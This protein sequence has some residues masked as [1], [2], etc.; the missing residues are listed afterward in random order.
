MSPLFAQKIEMKFGSVKEKVSEVL[1]RDSKDSIIGRLDIAKN[2]PFNQLP[3][4]SY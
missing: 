2:N 4:M 3:N 1:F